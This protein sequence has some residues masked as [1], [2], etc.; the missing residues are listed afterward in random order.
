M[1]RCIFHKKASI[2]LLR[3]NWLNWN[4]RL[5]L[6]ASFIQSKYIRLGYL[7]E[8]TSVDVFCFRKLCGSGFKQL[9]HFYFSINHFFSFL[10]NVF[11]W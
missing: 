6:I 11:E 4:T 5:D 3:R 8:L 1:A 10:Q 2:E 7:A 9:A